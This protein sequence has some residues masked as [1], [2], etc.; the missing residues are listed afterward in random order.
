MLTKASV[1]AFSASISGT[2]SHA[3]IQH[4]NGQVVE[5]TEAELPDLLLD[6]AADGSGMPGR[7]KHH[8]LVLGEW[9]ARKSA[10]PKAPALR[11]VG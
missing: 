4:T 11:L 9:F 6:L 5:I 10:A 1:Y 3:K 8:H 7:S 2:S